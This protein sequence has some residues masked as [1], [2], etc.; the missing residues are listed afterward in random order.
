MYCADKPVVVFTDTS[1]LY[2]SSETF[3]PLPSPVVVPGYKIK[4]KEFGL[5]P[6]PYLT[7]KGIVPIF[8]PNKVILLALAY[9]T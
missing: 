8:C 6:K 2:R 1:P 5:Q 4:L 3:S 9:K 7:N